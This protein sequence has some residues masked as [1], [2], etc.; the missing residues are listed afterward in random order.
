[1]KAALWNKMAGW[2]ASLGSKLA[3]DIFVQQVLPGLWGL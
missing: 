1:M 3:V 2:L